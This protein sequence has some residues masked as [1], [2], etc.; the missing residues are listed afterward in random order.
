[1]SDLAKQHSARG[2]TSQTRLP[3]LND[4]ATLMARAKAFFPNQ[5]L[6]PGTDD[7]YLVAWGEIAAKYGTERFDKA[8]WNVLR[9][10]VFF[11]APVE[12]E[13]ECREIHIISKEM[14]G[15]GMR[16]WKCV[17][18]AYQCAGK[19]QPKFCT[20]C[21]GDMRIVAMGSESAVEMKRFML[22]QKH[23]PEKFV[24]IGELYEEAVER[25][26]IRSEM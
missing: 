17:S 6:P 20:E 3:Q 26:A 11:P 4:L 25:L 5:T 13:N 24:S 9:R 15:T 2:K 8:L 21:N 1:M 10:S 16:V 14:S 7:L 19:L 18:C 22:D 23:H 12:I